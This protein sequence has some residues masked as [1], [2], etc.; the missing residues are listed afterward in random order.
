MIALS[1][2][3]LI[4][5]P[6]FAFLL[7]A[8]ALVLRG[9]H[10]R[11]PVLLALTSPTERFVV[12]VTRTASLI[13]TVAS[14]IAIVGVLTSPSGLIYL[15]VDPWLATPETHALLALDR[16][17][18]PLCGI[19]AFLSAIVGAFSQT[20]LHRERGHGRFFLLFNLFVAGMFLLSLAGS[21]GM[22]FVGWELVGLTSVLLIG[23]FQEREAPVRNALRALAT[24]R[25]C[26][27][28]LIVAVLLMSRHGSEPAGMTFAVG[29][30]HATLGCALLV[31]AAAGKS[32]QVPLGG[33]LSGAMEGPTPSS[34]VFYGG[35]SVH[36]GVY[37]LARV[38]PAM[39]DM[40]ALRAIV[41]LIGA[42]TALYATLVGRV[43]ADAKSAL[44]AST[45]AQ[46]GLMFV[47]V[48]LGLPE[49]AMVHM[50][51]HACLRTWQMLTAP[52]TLQ[53]LGSMRDALGGPL[54]RVGGHFERM[55]PASLRA[56]LYTKAL[57]GFGVDAL[58]ERV[59]VK[60]VLGLAHFVVSLEASWIALLTGRSDKPVLLEPRLASEKSLS[61]KDAHQ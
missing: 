11:A 44:A 23:F 56:K 55:L 50:V 42:S 5:S 7:V 2:A 47:E 33:W 31:L 4:A 20:Y 19:T 51:G 43:Q 38:A 16:M 12:S 15:S 10:K 48:G 40:L 61:G 46:L 52:G 60:P 18:T 35:L 14:V 3:V 32:A 26:D 24:Y 21:L 36:A 54:P 45:Q 22:F 58:V 17:G 41:V 30:P 37:L 9:D 53:E 59:V 25:V 1:L 34:A 6:L 49:L 39:T 29:G 57:L 8:A 13:T 28:G 27:I